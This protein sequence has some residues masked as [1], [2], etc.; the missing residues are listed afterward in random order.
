MRRRHVIP[1]LGGALLAWPRVGLAQTAGVPRVGWLTVAPVASPVVQQLVRA[2]RDGLGELGYVD[3]RSITFEYRSAEGQIERLGEMA[4]HLVR[5]KVDVIAAFSNAATHAARQ[6]T[7]VIPI[8]CFNLGN[9]VGEGLVASLARPGG[10]VTGF[11]VFA[12][13]LVPEMLSLLKQDVPKVSRVAALWSPGSL[14]EG[15]VTDMLR[16]TEAGAATLGV[17]LVPVRFREV[18][19][20]DGAFVTMTKARS[21]ALLVLPSPL[22]NTEG[23]RIAT[24]A[25]RHR[26]P[27]ISWNRYFVEAGGLMSYGSN[28]VE[29]WRRGAVYTDRILKGASP[30]ELPIEQP[31]TF[32]LVI[33]Q[34]TAATLGLTIPPGLLMQT[35]QVLQ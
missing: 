34:K 19:Q 20:L 30:G 7:T 18:E 25:A 21:E 3:G 13:E 24:L 5:L 1:L 15:S 14:A 26:L 4:A 8:V 6:A 29:N 28:L 23:R 11:T 9:P 22:T 10:N 16:K 27:S 35:D 12:P 31:T 2:F 33:N 32:E 17:E